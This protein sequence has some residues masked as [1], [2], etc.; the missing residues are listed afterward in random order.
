MDNAETAIAAIKKKADM[1]NA[2]ADVL[3]NLKSQESWHMH[4]DEETGE[5]VDDEGEYAENHLTA[6]RNAIAAIKKL[7][8]V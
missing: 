6:I 8:G 1:M 4:T 3:E 2:Y 5:R 7:A